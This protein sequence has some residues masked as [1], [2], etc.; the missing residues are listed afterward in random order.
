[1]SLGRGLMKR[2]RGARCR[3]NEGLATGANASNS[4]LKPLGCSAAIEGRGR[5]VY[6]E[7]I[8]MWAV[9]LVRHTYFIACRCSN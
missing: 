6:L 9:L 5:E 7:P 8:V 2:G 1:M 3:G 4:Q